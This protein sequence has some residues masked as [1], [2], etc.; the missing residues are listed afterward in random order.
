M[1]LTAAARPSAPAWR[2]SHGG[3]FWVIA[4]A[5]TVALAFSTV[6][7]PLYGIY[8]QRDGFP[9]WVI[10]VIYAMYAVGVVASLYLA[11]HVSDWFGR[12]RVI[13][14]ATLVEAVSALIFL[15]WPDVAGLII[16]RLIGGAGIGAMVATA[17]AH[18]SELRLIARPHG[19]P[20]RSGLISTVVNSGGLAIGPLISGVLVQFVDSPLTVPYAIF[21]GLLLLSA[22]AI[23]LVP[24]TVER[25]EERPAYRPQAM[26]LPKDSR[27]KFYGAATGAFAA[28]ALM[29]L[30]TAL[31]PTLLTLVFGQPSRL[32]GAVAT[33]ALMGAAAVAQVVFA[34]LTTRPQLQAGFAL[35][36][37]GLV[38]VA[39]SVLTVSMVL[40]FAGAVI[41][42]A[43]TGLA[44][45][46][47]VATAASLAEPAVRGEVLAALFLGAY[48][49]LSIPVLAIGVTLIWLPSPAAVVLFS[50]LDLILLGW[51][52]RRTLVR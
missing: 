11:G 43:G 28:F 15:V 35:M 1:T 45:R 21:L 20:A 14:A 8:Q 26:S 34:R 7:T 5:F 31:A 40:F 37:A 17:T 18:L 42:G 30:F 6:P 3:G 22:L 32:F 2:V 50:A 16:A 27:P 25:T 38:M 29:G 19:D 12:R 33:F 9:T 4:A 48:A 41:G 47:S 36:A 46:S 51:A 23:S 24:E 39:V 10:T 49:G 13:L 52:A 44:F